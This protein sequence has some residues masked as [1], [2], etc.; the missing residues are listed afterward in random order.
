MNAINRN[1]SWEDSVLKVGVKY[2]QLTFSFLSITSLQ[3]L[4]QIL[5]NSPMHDLCPRFQSQKTNWVK[6]NL[7][8]RLTISQI[9]IIIGMIQLSVAL[10]YVQKRKW[11]FKFFFNQVSKLNWLFWMTQKWHLLL[12]FATGFWSNK[13]KVN[14]KKKVST[15]T[16]HLSLCG[17]VSRSISKS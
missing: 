7:Y 3:N 9:N 13:T 14:Y 4:F 12:G 8:S 1:T 16:D 17:K 10:N 15:H 6:E 2:E 5:P 11:T